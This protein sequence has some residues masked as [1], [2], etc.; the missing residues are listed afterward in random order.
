MAAPP[1]SRSLGSDRDLALH[2]RMVPAIIFDLAGFFD[3]DLAGRVR[4]QLHV[5]VAVPGGGG[6]DDEITVHP[7][8]CVADMSRDCRRSEGKALHFDPDRLGQ[9][10]A[11]G[12]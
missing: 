10:A 12:G 8:D 3:D 1:I 5:P 11:P 6:M 2:V 9:S 4:T 7:F